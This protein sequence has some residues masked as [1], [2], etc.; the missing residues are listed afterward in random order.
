MPTQDG[1]ALAFSEESSRLSLQSTGFIKTTLGFNRDIHA[2]ENSHHGESNDAFLPIMISHFL[3]CI[4][5][6]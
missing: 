3:L 1:N 4:F 5:S 2:N 6:G